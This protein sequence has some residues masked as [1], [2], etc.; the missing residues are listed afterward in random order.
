MLIEVSYV[1]FG[2]GG[3]I[4]LICAALMGT[5]LIPMTRLAEEALTACKNNTNLVGALMLL[6]FGGLKYAFEEDPAALVLQSIVLI[7]VVL[8]RIA[9]YSARQPLW[10]LL[11]ML[12]VSVVGATILVFGFDYP[13]EGVDALW[14]LVAGSILLGCGFG[15]FG[16]LHWYSVTVISGGISMVIACALPFLGILV[17]EPRPFTPTDVLSV[18]FVL[19]IFYVLANSL[20]WRGAIRKARARLAP[21]QKKRRQS[22]VC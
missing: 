21:A 13:P 3:L 16:V 14:F 15:L 20:D 7:G 11:I 18:Y 1:V 6:V 5:R 2:Y 17:N 9:W 19:N 10:R 4:A 22:V 12:V 8:S